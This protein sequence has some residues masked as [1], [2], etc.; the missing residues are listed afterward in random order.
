MLRPLLHGNKFNSLLIKT[1]KNEKF[2]E[3]DKISKLVGF[4]NDSSLLD[5]IPNQ[6]SQCLI[7]RFPMS[8]IRSAY[9]PTHHTRVHIDYTWRTH[10]AYT[11]DVYTWTYT[12]LT[13]NIHTAYTKHRHN[14]HVY[15]QRTHN[16]LHSVHTSYPPRTH[17]LHAALTFYTHTQP[18]T[19]ASCAHDACTRQHQQILFYI[20]FVSIIFILFV[21]SNFVTREVV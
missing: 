6:M 13:P 8:M 2:V 17:N 20:F 18:S 10:T 3:P 1:D 5:S 11:R 7:Q 19:V 4:L 16:V 9:T 14:V 12:Q 21:L 15:T